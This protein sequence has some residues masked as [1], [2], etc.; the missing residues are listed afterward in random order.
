MKI[1]VYLALKNIVKNKIIS[2][3]AGLAKLIR[4]YPK[5]PLEVGMSELLKT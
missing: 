3:K 5:T 1:V 2:L 4:T